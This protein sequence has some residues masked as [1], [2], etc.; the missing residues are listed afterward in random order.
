MKE[1]EKIKQ[2]SI[3]SVLFILIIII[4]LLTYKRP[5]NNYK[6]NT[7]STLE[8][9]SSLNYFASLEDINDKNN[10][11]IDVRSAY[12]F[13]KGHL[14]KAIN[15]HTPDFLKESSLNLFKDLKS[16]DK[17]AILYGENP[18]EVNMPFMFLYQLGYENVKILTAKNSYINNKLT[19]KIVEVEKYKNDVVAFI[20]KSRKNA[21][22]KT[23]EKISIPKKTV[24][25]KKKK[26]RIAEGG[27]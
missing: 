17:T 23:I 1:L 12:E 2:I 22:V 25:V 11:L 24:T 15:I 10:L 6:H 4:G 8:K 9:L 27:C 14:S 18:H 19:T 21:N 7:K 5:K 16:A 13:D 26:K 20:N 3:A